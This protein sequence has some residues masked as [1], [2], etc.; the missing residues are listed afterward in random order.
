MSDAHDDAAV[1]A[2]AVQ[3]DEWLHQLQTSNPAIEAVDRT[4][5]DPLR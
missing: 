4:D 3:I 5:D 1:S 2:L